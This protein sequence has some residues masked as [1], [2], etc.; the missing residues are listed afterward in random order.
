MRS[1]LYHP[2]LNGTRL[3][4]ESKPPPSLTMFPDSAAEF[5]MRPTPTITA[6]NS[7]RTTPMDKY[8]APDRRKTAAIGSMR[9][10]ASTIA[11]DRRWT[12]VSDQDYRNQRA[13][14]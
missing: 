14:A 13:Y 3:P 4:L 11:E 8:H 2:I 7:T 5:P 1:N 6:P 10:G 12:L 9:G